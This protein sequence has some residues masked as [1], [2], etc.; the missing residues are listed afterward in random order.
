MIDMESDED[1]PAIQDHLLVEADVSGR[2]MSLR[3]VVIR[4]TQDQLWLGLASPDRRLEAIRPKQAVKLTIARPGAALL[5]QS[6]FLGPLGGS[7]SRV[8]A[9]ARPEKLDRVQRRNFVRCPIDI[10]LRFRQIDPTTWE[11][12]GRVADTVTRNLS[13]GGLLFV[14]D[15]D[16]RVGDDLDLSL[17][18]SSWDHVSMSGVV[19][20]LGRPADG[21]QRDP[22]GPEEAEVGV[23]FT[24]ITSLDQNRIVRLILLAE[25]RRREDAQRDRRWASAEPP[26]AAPQTH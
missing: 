12:R 6:T 4:S 25:H 14:S 19:K 13:P 16:V 3:A 8:F 24:R 21:G 17:P 15:A 2:P 5:G 20:R 11:P 18:L 26:A 9:V 7:K 23:A 1:E 22:G 10:P